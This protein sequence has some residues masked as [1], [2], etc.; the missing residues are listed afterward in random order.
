MLVAKLPGSTYA[1]ATTK[2]GPMSATTERTRDGT[3]PAGGRAARLTMRTPLRGK[4]RTPARA[5]HVGHGRGG[6]PVSGE[7]LDGL[8]DGAEVVRAGRVEQRVRLGC[9]CL[10][11][12]RV[13]VL[14]IAELVHAVRCGP[15]RPAAVRA[16]GA[17][18]Q[19]PDRARVVLV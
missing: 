2:A 6:R 14:Q 15:R 13:R 7:L 8:L 3:A 16:V 4:G 18:G 9:G 1:T 10:A 17:V 11:A 12:Q 19:V 5:R